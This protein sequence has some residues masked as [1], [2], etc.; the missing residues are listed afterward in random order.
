ML[1]IALF[2]GCLA[3]PVYTLFLYPLL[4]GI[5]AKWRSNP[6]RSEPQTKRISVIIPVLNGERFIAEKLR[7]VLALDY[8]RD[9]ME[10]LVVSDASTDRTE[11]IVG[12]FVGDGVRFLRLPRGG[13]PAAINAAIP[14]TQGEILLLTD[15]RQILAPD[16]LQF[17]VNCF[18]DPRVGAV[19]GN[20]LIRRDIASGEVSVELYWRYEMW[21]RKQLSRIDSIFGA[22][23]PFYAIRRELVVPIPQDVLLD[24]VYLPLA[25]FF[26]GYRLIVETRACAYDYPTTLRTEFRR[27]VRT[28]AG[29]Y[30]ILKEYPALLGFRNRMLFHFVSYKV[31]RLLMP[32]SLS[33]VLVA[34]FFLP[35]HVKWVVLAVEGLC[36]ALAILDPL[37]PCRFLLKCISS[38]LRTFAV[39]IIA[40]VFGLQILF[41]SPRNLWKETTIAF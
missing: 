30:Q 31:G 25:C 3:Q 23:G 16:S 38:P 12:T 28:I 29:L 11:S 40:T 36:C 18:A 8:P 13:K 4:L 22:V 20:L 32:Y 41:V 27:K 7:S 33:V 1:W 5:L 34:G 26:R 24:D 15:V 17:L 39:L 6:I 14:L 35:V 9:L 37:I 10:V 19:S 2:L 21:I